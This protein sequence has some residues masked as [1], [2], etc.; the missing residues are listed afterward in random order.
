[1]FSGSQSDIVQS[2][3]PLV[4]DYVRASGGIH[5]RLAASAGRTQ[6]IERGESGGYRVR[7]PRVTG[8]CEAVLIN[9]G[10]G[11]AG[12]DHMTAKIS[13]IPQPR[14]FSLRKPPKKSTARKARSP[15]SASS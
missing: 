10:G 5:V 12:G 3:V 14:R 8:V 9:T 13:L 11:M 4:P 1:M 7:F 15:K 2:A 6:A